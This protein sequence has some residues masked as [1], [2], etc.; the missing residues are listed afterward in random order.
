M[1]KTIESTLSLRKVNLADERGLLV[2]IKDVEGRRK[3]DHSPRYLCKEDG[4]RLF[5]SGVG[6]LKKPDWSMPKNTDK[7][8]LYVQ[9]DE[10]LIPIDQLEELYYIVGG[11]YV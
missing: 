1:S 11:D 4:G 5:V 8:C 2:A 10:M 9:G 7:G 3:R 6:L